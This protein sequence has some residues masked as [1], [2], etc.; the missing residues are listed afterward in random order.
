MVHLCEYSYTKVAI[1]TND[2]QR[3]RLH[4]TEEARQQFPGGTPLLS[5]KLP[6][7][8]ESFSN[9]LVKTFLDGPLPKETR[10]ALSLRT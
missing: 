2:K 1:V 5:L 6:V 4:Y 10:D 7:S 9:N 3:L 8:D